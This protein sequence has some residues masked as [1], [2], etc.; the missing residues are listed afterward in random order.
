MA[1]QSPKS[2]AYND[3]GQGLPFYQGKK[4]FADRYLD[5]PTTWTTQVTKRAEP[6]DILMSV[7]APVGAINETREQ[8]CIGRGLAAIRAGKEVDRDFLWYALSWLQPSITGNAGA[9]FPSI[10][11]D[12]IEDL[13]IPLPPLN[14]QR[15]IVAFLD[16]AFAALDRARA[17]AEANLADSRDFAPSLIATAFSKDA[18][19][20][21]HT[22]SDLVN[23]GI[24]ERPIDGNHGETHPKKEDFVVCGVPFIMASDLADGAVDQKRCAFLTRA[25]A[26]GLRKGFAKDGDVLLS[27]K[28]TIGRAAILS[29]DL[30][31]VMLTPQVTYYRVLDEAR[32]DR[33]FLYHCMRSAPFQRRMID[34]AKSGATRAYIGIT[35]Q[36]ELQI[37]LPDVETQKRLT[38]KI[39][40]AEDKM[41]AVERRCAERL[42][43]IQELRQALLK[44]AYAGKMN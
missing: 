21:V 30:D 32:L 24:I 7:R 29:T 39:E 15:R 12:D 31:Y 33:T 17:N 20:P 8:I 26:D 27:H 2:T 11:K 4:E 18:P 6:N 13:T 3:K 37:P 28:G 16:Q 43:E 23:L 10:S 40:D 25:Q 1:G 5:P 44:S 34:I 41:R 9:V 38:G 35:R 42:G 19:W 36:L 14:E 22:V